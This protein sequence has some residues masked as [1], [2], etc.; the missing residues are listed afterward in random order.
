M[1]FSMLAIPRKFPWV[2]RIPRW[3][4][5]PTPNANIVE[6]PR[7]FTV[8]CWQPHIHKL[9]KLEQNDASLKFH[10]NEQTET[11][12]RLVKTNDPLTFRHRASCI[13][14]QVFH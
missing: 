2:V 8:Q 1:I 9:Y 12:D 3:S 5:P 14:G 10:K 6:D 11:S 7:G 4:K 13:L